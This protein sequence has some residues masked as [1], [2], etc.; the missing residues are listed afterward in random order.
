MPYLVCAE[1]VDDQWIAHVPDLPGCYFSHKDRERAIQAIPKAIEDY[2]AWCKS[3][4]T[5]VSGLTGPMIVD[6]V[7]RCWDFEDGRRVHA[8]FASDR[9]PLFEEELSGYEQLLRAS[10][11]DLLAAVENLTTEDL[12]YEF[13]NERWPI[14]GILMHVAR[15]EWFYMDRLA[16]AFPQEESKDEPFTQLEKVRKWTLYKLPALAASKGVVTMGGETWSARKVL[17]RTLWHER[18]HTAHIL[19]LRK[20]LPR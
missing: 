15:A 19:E 1:E 9:P 18:D 7:I 5:M 2:I 14:W 17:R 10:R 6:E 13:P 20:R 11:K 16:L 12:I 8:F 4:Q 3:H